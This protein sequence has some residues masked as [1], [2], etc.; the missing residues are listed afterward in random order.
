MKILITGANGLLGQKITELLLKEGINFV[1]TGRSSSGGLLKMDITSP[2]ETREVIEKERPDIIINTAA[3]T[4]VDECETR[5]E[6]CFASNVRG[7]ENV[8]SA[9]RSVNAHLIHLSTDFIFDGKH[10]PLDENAIPHPV[11]YYGE[12]K[13]E[14]EK[15]VRNSNFSWSILRTVLVYGIAPNMSR[16]NIVLWV[17]RSLEDKKPIQVVNDQ[18]RTPTLAEDL[19]MSCWLAAKKQAKGIYHISGNEMLTP[20]QI[21]MHTA[22][23][24]KLDRGLITEVDSSQFTQAA[25]RP[26]KTGFIIAKAE[27]ELGFKPHSLEEGLEIISKQI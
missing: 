19:A 11:N 16:S 15:I 20:F 7:V 1:A 23:F 17:K 21:A 3:M 8:V 24:F 9:A 25:K 10:G 27:R 22:D 13:L 14:G 12:C 18:W 26:M 6:P 4:Q 2:A 5:R